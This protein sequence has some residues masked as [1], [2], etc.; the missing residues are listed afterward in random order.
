MN[1]WKSFNNMRECRS[2]DFER[3]GDIFNALDGLRLAVSVPP[4]EQRTDHL[5]PLIDAS[6]NSTARID[7]LAEQNINKMEDPGQ[8]KHNK[9]LVLLLEPTIMPEATIGWVDSFSRWPSCGS[10]NG[11]N[12]AIIICRAIVPNASYS[13]NYKNESACVYSST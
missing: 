12:T 13:K 3:P 7:R 10:L 11:F 1:T 8:C 6:N 9:L 2:F 4:F 5:Q